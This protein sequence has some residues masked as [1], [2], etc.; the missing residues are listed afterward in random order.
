MYE[1]RLHPDANEYIQKLDSKS[2]RI[3]KDNLR[4]LED[5]P[6]PRPDS[7]LGDAEKVTVNGDEYFR[8]HI[9]RTHTAFYRV[10]DSED[11]V[12]VI[13]IVDID[14]AHKMYD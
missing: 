11:Q 4:K 5:D 3:V 13:N 14:T 7:K 2:Q 10:K 8:L 9:S 1:I 12:H 6:Y